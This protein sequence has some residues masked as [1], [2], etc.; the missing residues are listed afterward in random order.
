MSF[1]TEFEIATEEV[2][3]APWA[4]KPNGEAFFCAFC[5]HDFVPGDE[6][7]MVFTNDISGAGG[8]PLVCRPCFVTYDGLEGLRERWL[9][10]NDEF[11]ERFKYFWVRYRD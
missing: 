3:K 6:Y 8:N 10:I 7:R 5:G 9:V 11:K 4:C 1:T 2:C